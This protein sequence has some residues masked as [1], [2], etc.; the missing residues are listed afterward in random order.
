MI[1]SA[2]TSLVLAAALLAARTAAAQSLST[3]SQVGLQSAIAHYIDDHS[4][5]DAYLHVDLGSGVI[6]TYSPATQH[7]MI[8]RLREGVGAL[9]E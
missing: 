2:F 6:K 9:L 1:K 4:V 7:P 8:V 3:A 5:G